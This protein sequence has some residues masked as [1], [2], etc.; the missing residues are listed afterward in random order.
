MLTVP[1]WLLI[2][3]EQS[4]IVLFV[5]AVFFFLR[6]RKLKKQV[7]LYSRVANA[8]TQQPIGSSKQ[9]LSPP[10]LKDLGI[11]RE[12]L[13][14]AEQ[15]VKNLERFRELFF[16]LKDRLAVLMEHQRNMHE[17]MQQAGLPL[18]EQ[19]ALKAAFEQ[20]KREKTILE[21]HLQQVEDE[22]DVLMDNSKKSSVRMTEPASA[23]N[24][25]NEQQ[26]K[27]GKLIQEIADLEIE[28]A[29]GH[30]IQTTINQLNHQTDELTMAIEVLQDENQF[31]NEQV[32]MLLQQQHQKDQQLSHEIDLITSQLAEKQQAYDDLYKK[33]IRLESE[34]LRART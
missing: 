29:A 23:G 18:E 9:I 25:I 28:A 6:S 30:R 31:L 16:D 10:D 20:L 17:H 11:V 34:Y 32:Q 19:K 2:T 22:L 24:V 5:L 33:H 27:I 15:Q 4:I 14:L 7:L 21:Q 3:A 1:S 12:R 13:A 26:V 8:G